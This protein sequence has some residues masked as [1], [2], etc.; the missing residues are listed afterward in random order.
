ML[1]RDFK[2]TLVT[3][4]LIALAVNFQAKA[5]MD[6]QL[7]QYWAVPSYY[8]PGSIFKFLNRRWGT[9]LLLQQ[10]NVGLFSTQT[11][12][13]QLA[14]KKKMMGGWLSVGAQVGLI[15]QSFKGDSIFV[16]END[17]YHTSVDDAIPKGVISGRALDVAVGV[18]FIHKWFWVSLSGTHLTS[19]TITMKAGENEED[20]YEFSTGRYFYLMAGSNIPIKNTLFEIQPS[21][22]VKTDTK[23]FQYEATA[24]MRYNKF[25]SFGVAYRHKDAVSAMIGAE[26][27]NFFVGYAYDYPISAMN[28]ATHHIRVTKLIETKKHT[29]R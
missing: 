23:F 13:A 27:K 9:G 29:T 21:V 5:Q 19:P 4:L 6:A 14:W 3:M 25:L 8:N 12:A 16:P 17:Q 1:N 22:F 28:K 2:K 24:R 11:I 15:N 18:S 7:T 26:F 10:E 20:L